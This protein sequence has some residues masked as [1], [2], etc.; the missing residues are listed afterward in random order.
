MCAKRILTKGPSRPLP[1]SMPSLCFT[2]CIVSSFSGEGG[3]DPTIEPGL[4][5]HSFLIPV[6]SPPL[7]SKLISSIKYSFHWLQEA[8]TACSHSSLFSPGFRLLLCWSGYTENF[9][10]RTGK[11]QVSGQNFGKSKSVQI[12][13]NQFCWANHIR[14]IN[15]LTP[16]Q[17]TWVFYWI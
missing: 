6:L 10:W 7:L 12:Q 16:P 4:E 13:I 1:V 17:Y 2:W 9:A 8:G 15:V 3:S 11:P 14:C 5:I